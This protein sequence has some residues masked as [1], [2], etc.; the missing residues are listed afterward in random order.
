MLL[1]D[2]SDEQHSV[3]DRVSTSGIS[4]IPWLINDGLALRTPSAHSSSTKC[5]T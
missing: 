3:F 5:R 1:L 2:N 4:G